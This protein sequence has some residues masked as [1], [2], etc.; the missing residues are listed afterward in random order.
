MA[1]NGAIDDTSEAADK[2]EEIDHGVVVDDEEMAT[3]EW[4]NW[5]CVIIP[6]RCFCYGT[7]SLQRRGSTGGV[8]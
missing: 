6:N 5:R 1:R 3:G 7:D 2:L 8:N 4:H